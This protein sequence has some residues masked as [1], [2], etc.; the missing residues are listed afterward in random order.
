MGVS[1]HPGLQQGLFLIALLAFPIFGAYVGVQ[2]AGQTRR[3]LLGG[4][5]L[6]LAS[7]APMI[8]LRFSSHPAVQVG[9]VFLHAGVAAACGHLAYEFSS[10]YWSRMQR[11]LFAAL[12]AGVGVAVTLVIVL[13]VAMSVTGIYP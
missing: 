4:A 1:L 5:A 12:G 8:V 2:F 6:I 3:V 10:P 11:G 9:T 7:V 13:V